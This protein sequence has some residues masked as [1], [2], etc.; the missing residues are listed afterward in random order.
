VKAIAAMSLNRVIGRDNKIPWHLPEDFRWFKQLT[1]GH[2]VLMGRKTFESLGRPLPNRTNIVVTRKPRR[3]AHDEQF[4]AA[5]GHARIG[6]WR[7]R[8]GQPYQLG[9]ERFTERDIW[10]VRDPSKLAD[11]HAVARPSR[12]LFLIGGAQLYA[13]LLDRCADLYLSVVQ[14]EVEGDAFFP[15]FDDRFE[16]A[17]VPLRTADF[18]VRHYR[19][20]ELLSPP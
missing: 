19:N 3:L 20:R 14:R 7:A 18:E 12:E 10:L 5:F 4:R 15:E 9:F 1:T 13:Q 16:L 2:F 8:L 11:A 17:D 6:H